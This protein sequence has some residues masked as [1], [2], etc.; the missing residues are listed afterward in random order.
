MVNKNGLSTVK[1][2]EFSGISMNDKGSKRNLGLVY[3]TVENTIGAAVYTT[4]DVVAAPVIVSKANDNITFKKRAILINSG[5]ANSF[6]GAKGIADANECLDVLSDNL[7]IPRYECYVGS[8]GVIGRYLETKPIE[9]SIPSLINNLSSN[10]ANEFIEAI[11]T[12]DTKQ[13]Q[14]SIEFKIQDKTVHIAACAKGSGMIMLNMA[15]ML[16]VVTT[17]VAITEDLLKRALKEAVTDTFNCITVDGDTSTNDSVFLLANGLAGNSI[18]S[19]LGFE[20]EQFRLHLTELLEDMAK[21]IVNDGEGVTK[22][23]TINVLHTPDKEKARKIA[24]SIANSPLVKTAF[25]G[26]DMN[27]GRIMMAIGKAHTQMNCDIIDI[28]LNNFKIIKNGEPTIGTTDYEQAEKSLKNHE[29]SL[30]ID[31]KN[32]DSEIRIWTCDFSLEYI[33]INS[34]YTT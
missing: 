14:A 27:W 31:F 33:K 11:M 34:D 5:N 7:K 25:Y 23:I 12:T 18:I 3:S 29:I 8:T 6:T 4:N 16:S 13:K 10:T 32:G 1:G 21:Q 22:F 9:R 20:Y 26:E 19:E 15:T 30:E 28:R 17:D 24:M 2:F